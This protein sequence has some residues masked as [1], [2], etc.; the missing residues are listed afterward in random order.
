MGAAVPGAGAAACCCVLLLFLVL[1]LV[2]L[3][4]LLLILLLLLLP[5]LLLL[6]A[7]CVLVYPRGLLVAPCGS[8]TVCSPHHASRKQILQGVL[9]TTSLGLVKISL[10]LRRPLHVRRVCTR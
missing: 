5:L 10:A 6:A 4:L 2:L 3:L 7:G 8:L 1:V 9:P